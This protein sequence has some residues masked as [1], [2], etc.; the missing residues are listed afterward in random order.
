MANVE[1]VCRQRPTKL[2]DFCLNSGPL[3]IKCTELR[4]WGG[5]GDRAVFCGG[6]LSLER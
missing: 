3:F 2:Q 5:E 4:T 6:I 1:I